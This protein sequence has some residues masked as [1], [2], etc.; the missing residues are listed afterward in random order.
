MCQSL[1]HEAIPKGSGC[2]Q[3]GQ[4]GACEWQNKG[5]INVKEK[6]EYG[7]EVE[8][9]RSQNYMRSKCEMLKSQGQQLLHKGK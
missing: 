6:G 3:R 4:D 7:Q 1:E 8:S 9:C 5:R 2:R